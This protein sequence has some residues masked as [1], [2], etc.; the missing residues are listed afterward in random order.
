LLFTIVVPGTMAGLIPYQ[1]LMSTTS[2]AIGPVRFA[3][4]P[5]FITGTGIYLWCAWDFAFTGRGTPA[6][7]DPPKTLIVRGL[8]QYVRN[9]MY[10]GVLS[11]VLGQCLYFGSAA[12]LL[13]ACVA[14]AIVNT[15]VF[16]YEEPTLTRLF[17]D[18]YREYCASV[19]RWIPR[20]PRSRR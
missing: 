20:L 4:I 10:L 16:L 5:L 11:I 3:G 9:P 1:I 18:Q 6:P 13:Y 17:G 12:V 8:Y 19:P 2:Y 14:F 15:F 7:I